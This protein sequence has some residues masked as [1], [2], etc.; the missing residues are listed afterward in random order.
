[1]ASMEQRN[2]IQEG[3]DQSAFRKSIMPIREE[4]DPEVLMGMV[5]DQAA[6]LLLD[7]FEYQEKLKRRIRNS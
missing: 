3:E 2:I 5:A 7:C 1:M 6:R 4:G